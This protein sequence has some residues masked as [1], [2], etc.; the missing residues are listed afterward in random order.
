[1]PGD[2]GADDFDMI[3]KGLRLWR[4]FR[5]WQLP[6]IMEAKECQGTAAWTGMLPLLPSGPGGVHKLDI[7]GP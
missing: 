3:G 7:H 1:M 6:L 4:A 2:G 5:A